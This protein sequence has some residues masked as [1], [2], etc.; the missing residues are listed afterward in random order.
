MIVAIEQISFIGWNSCIPHTFS[1]HVS[2]KGS[3]F[4]SVDTCFQT[5]ADPRNIF[6]KQML[7]IE[8]SRSAVGSVT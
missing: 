5:G 3:V 7:K 6:D 1:F 4:Y 2:R 8:Q